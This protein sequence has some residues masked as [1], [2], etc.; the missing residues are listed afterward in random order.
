MFA[1][2]L[3]MRGATAKL[4]PRA[5]RLE[6]GRGSALKTTR[7][8]TMR[9]MKKEGSDGLFM[10]STSGTSRG[11]ERLIDPRKRVST[12][13]NAMERREEKEERIGRKDVAVN[14]ETMKLEID[15][16][17]VVSAV[18]IKKKRLGKRP[19]QVEYSD[20]LCAFAAD[21]TCPHIKT[22]KRRGEPL[23]YRKSY[24]TYRVPAS[25]DTY[26]GKRCCKTCYSKI[27]ASGR[28]C[29]F[30]ADG[31]CTQAN[32]AKAKNVRLVYVHL[33]KVKA[34]WSAKHA[35]KH[36][37]ISCYHRIR[38]NGPS[39]S[40][41]DLSKQKPVG[42]ICSFYE[43]GT[44]VRANNCLIRNVPIRYSNIRRIVPPNHPRAGEYC[45]VSCF[46]KIQAQGKLCVRAKEGTCS[47][48]N[49]CKK[50]KI[51]PVAYSRLRKLPRDHEKYPG[52]WICPACL[53]KMQSANRTCAFA[54]DG[55]C[56][57]SKHTREGEALSISYRVPEWHPYAGEN[58]YCCETCFLKLTRTCAFEKDEKKCIWSGRMGPLGI[59]QKYLDKASIRVVPETSSKY[60]GQPCCPDCYRRCIQETYNHKK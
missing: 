44:C 11:E 50:N 54:K 30:A 39:R 23:R 43:D 46:K 42:R 24:V 10:S 55:T 8:A 1:V 45:C 33:I 19:K 47:F 27:L 36:C 51:D 15:G 21:G 13:G 16:G 53:S 31:E 17:D 59:P 7:V 9:A 49:N 28:I 34:S 58:K 60:A 57:Y 20:E 52:E 4:T 5:A 18:E 38:K 2:S 14:Y 40:K 35:G 32:R 3:A 12:F 37:C 48:F 25:H 6:S 22:C 29:C 41:I 26:P 56:I